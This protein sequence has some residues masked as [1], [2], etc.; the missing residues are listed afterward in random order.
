MGN[1]QGTPSDLDSF[2]KYA[3]LT[4]KH[5]MM[6]RERLEML[7]EA[8]LS[9]T[10]DAFS[11]AMK[12]KEEETERIFRIFDLSSSGKI[13]TLEFVCAL[14]LMAYANLREKCDLMFGL[15]DFDRNR[16]MNKQELI[17]LIKTVL[18][19]VN[20]I[21]SKGEC[22]I[23]EAVGIAQVIL[24]RY[25]TNGDASISAKEFYSFV[26]KDPDIVKMLL[27]YGLISIQDLRFNFGE[28]Q[29]NELP[30]PEADSDLENEIF[31][32]R[33]VKT[34]EDEAVALG[35]ETQM[36][37]GGIE[38]LAWHQ[39]LA[40]D[41]MIMDPDDPED[42]NGNPPNATLEIDHVYGFRCF[43]TRNNIKYSIENELIYHT[44]SLVI[45]DGE[46]QEFFME[47]TDDVTCLDVWEH[48]VASGQMGS[49]PSI[50]VWDSR[51]MELRAVFRGV[52]TVGVS[53][54]C[55]SNDGRKLAAVG[56]DEDQCVVVYDIEKGSQT[57]MNGR[58]DESLLANGKGPIVEIFDIKFEKSDKQIVIACMG[59]VNFVTY[60]NN[61]LRI[62]KGMWDSKYCSYQAIL[63]IGL[64]ENAVVV[65]SFKG[66]LLLWR[67]GRT[68]MAIS[69]AHK[70]PITTIHTC[71]K[72]IMILT[73]GKDGQI[74]WWD[75]NLKKIRAFNLA[76]QKDILLNNIKITALYENMDQ[77]AIL[78]GTRGGQILELINSELK[79]R[80][81]A[82][83][84][85]KLE[86]LVCHPT[87][88]LFY[89]SGEDQMLMLWDLNSK[90]LKEKK[91]FDY[92]I[93]TLDV[94][95]RY[96]VGGCGNG[97]VLLMEPYK[98]TQ[99]QDFKD[100][101]SEITC[102]KIVDEY[103][104]AFY[105]SPYFEFFVYSIKQ[106]FKKLLSIPGRPGN[107]ISIDYSITQRILVTFDNQQL[108]CIDLAQRQLIR[109]KE[110]D[111]K[112][113]TSIYGWQIK[114]A[115][116]QKTDGTEIVTADRDGSKSVI[117][118]GDK[119]GQIK[120]YKYPAYKIN[121]SFY[122]YLGHSGR[123]SKLRFSSND[124]CL[125][126][127][128]ENE[129]SII[130]W[131]FQVEQNVVERSST[132]H[133]RNRSAFKSEL[134]QFDDQ[135]DGNDNQKTN[136]PFLDQI[137]MDEAEEE[138]LKL[139]INYLNLRYIFGVSTSYKGNTLY[140]Q[141]KYAGQQKIV[142]PIGCLCVILDTKIDQSAPYRKQNFYYGHTQLI[143][144]LSVHPK[145]QI[146]ATGTVGDEINLW[147]VDTRQTQVQIRGYHKNGIKNL[148]FSIDGTL[149]LTCGSDQF[150]SICVY[151][152]Q[153][154]RIICNSKVDKSPLTDCCFLGNPKII[155]FVTVGKYMRVWEIKGRNLS[156][157]QFPGQL[158][159][160]TFAFNSE[161]VCANDQGELMVIKNKQTNRILGHSGRVNVLI[162][163]KQNLYSGGDDG[164][165]I[166]WHSIQNQLQQIQ[167]FM[168]TQTPPLLSMD[169]RNDNIVF[170]TSTCDIKELVITAQI[171]S[172]DIIKGH[173]EDVRGLAISKYKVYTCSSDRTIKV[174]DIRNRVCSLN[175]EPY[176]YQLRSIDVYNNLIVCGDSKGFLY[177]LD[178]KLSPL[179]S[180][181]TNFNL[182]QKTIAYEISRVKF[183]P[184]GKRVCVGAQGGPS[185]IEIWTIN[186][187]DNTY[188]FDKERQIIN[189]GFTGG[190]LQLDW[191]E[192][193][194]HILASSTNY[195]LKCIS[196][197]KQRDVQY[198]YDIKWQTWSCIYGPG[199]QYI[200][201]NNPGE[202]ITA[203]WLHKTKEVKTETGNI[204]EYVFITGDQF[205]NLS[206]FKYPVT[207]RCCRTYK[208]HS[209]PINWIQFC[210]ETEAKQYAIS[211]GQKAIMIW[212]LEIDEPTI[213]DAETEK[214]LGINIQQQKKTGL[215]KYG[216]PQQ[217]QQVK[218]EE[219]VEKISLKPWASNIKEPSSYYKDPINQNTPPLI[220]LELEHAFGYRGNDCKNN[221]RFL[222]S[223]NIVYHSASLGIVL[224]M[225]VNQQKI[226]NM[227]EDDIISMDL[228]QDGIRVATGEINTGVIYVWD[229]NTLQALCKF[230][231][232]S[233]GIKSLQFS[234]F[235]QLVALAMDEFTT[236]AIFEINTKSES[237]G[238]LSFKY[239]S[240]KQ[241][242][243][244]IKWMNET[245]FYT[246]GP[247]HFKEWIFSSQIVISKIPIQD[248]LILN[249]FIIDDEEIYIADNR[250]KVLIYQKKVLQ[251]TLEHHTQQV[252][253]LFKTK[254][255]LFTGGKDQL[256]TIYDGKQ[257]KEDFIIQFKLLDLS[258][259]AFQPIIKSV[260]YFED[261]LVVGTVGCEIWELSTKDTKITNQ[262]K[263]T[264]KIMMKGHYAPQ[265]QSELWG[266]AIE[267][268]F[269]YSC[270]DDATL[271]QWSVSQRKQTLFIRTVQDSNFVDIK[272][273]ENGV[274]P[275]SVRGRSIAVNF[276]FI[277]VGFK[278]GGV[279]VYDRELKQKSY[280][281]VAKDWISDIKI[282]PNNEY[283][284]FGSHD[285][286]IYIYRI[287]EFVIHLKPLRKHSAFIKNVD[288]SVDSTKLISTCGSFD[289]IFWDITTGK[290]MPQG[291]NIL[292]DEKWATWTNILGWPV[293][294]IWR[295]DYNGQEINC[296]C[297]SNS[298]FAPKQPDNYYLL[299]VGND[300]NEVL[301]YRYPCINKKSEPI[302][303][304]G[305]SSPISQVK[306]TQDDQ[307]L[308]TMGGEDMTI[309]LW[310]VIKKL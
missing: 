263:F 18:T 60:D 3:G 10:K 137:K 199:L 85:G 113:F 236:I 174:W 305:H 200:Y 168:E 175:S 252:D 34:V 185:H 272:P 159:A 146:I 24:D 28:P 160:V 42:V 254:D 63:S 218:D 126:S 68:T 58:K 124:K 303:R 271:R 14:S 155:Q 220:D 241:I 129:K 154:N 147:D 17:I 186:S 78:I 192:D 128:G 13:E 54:L 180:V 196:L 202:D 156:F 244:E 102:I 69:D 123:I 112:S 11:L 197:T 278:D 119:Y 93:K 152:W 91:K 8:D 188:K 169:I 204:K 22:S 153:A 201:P 29:N 118:I 57:R 227:H 101:D 140:Q 279:R 66:Y 116:P 125:I 76:N 301:L 25:D 221:I 258:K 51:S 150:N 145:S 208:G 283:I 77:T 97:T 72:K 184:R 143:L 277:V 21:S 232:L 16:T 210:M 183:D 307:Y 5:V 62:V 292:R 203:V 257:I 132:T 177:L 149:L 36:N 108:W 157:D 99:L 37:G 206:L 41:N 231:Q 176:Q 276:D 61:V 304:R 268:D 193:S 290:Q 92:C 306:F 293:Q 297:R 136:K 166:L 33:V 111:W 281:K 86:A 161:L 122:R 96:L 120:L 164:K 194:T 240:G 286:C 171:H 230:N 298:P 31:K 80:V 269:I 226:F 259:Q 12:T 207:G 81:N 266:L 141:L 114:G 107:C 82:H 75:H 187:S 219:Y 170:L 103:L 253:A 308:V 178:E 74:G 282:S 189:C 294:G 19:T 261:K 190:I 20:A 117:A 209:G 7:S 213:L 49:K 133:S 47:H 195:E 289:L 121:C 274:Y 235:N 198:N 245:T 131:N 229:S 32:S 262:T 144:S 234:P 165:I 89:T 110:D 59:E 65:G 94:N 39:Q 23:Q 224:D 288:F 181:S 70:G 151:D 115:W 302:Q 1:T 44:G 299:A 6:L 26:S 105:S 52:L 256:I 275:D 251:H 280:F 211:V 291:R 295:D 242:I 215:E 35:I 239:Q 287:P 265:I 238:T 225:N 162:A 173:G 90:Q 285:N 87:K 163:V 134:N 100:R 223:G 104:I 233:K 249:T 310:R 139:P 48:L 98:L 64:L 56:M 84:D 248:K 255:Y 267:G 222:K 179:G 205:G 67:V 95:D 127:L 246:I 109:Y 53:N 212:Q 158:S 88:D 273:D 15:Y 45:K 40:K 43:D 191:S 38:Q 73:G 284:A 243:N 172:I 106:K 217:Q 4:I 130:Q 228:H 9:I 309:L 135:M 50:F 27:S 216:I 79:V 264:P 300:F 83:F 270:G 237:G 55:I 260:C 71:N 296:V 46:K 167:Q 250:G 148:K 247:Q 214:L 142:Y 30:V 2:R 138:Q 182:K